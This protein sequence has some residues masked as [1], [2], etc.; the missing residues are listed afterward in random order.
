MTN[1]V[2]ERREK[3]ERQ[4]QDATQRI[5]RAANITD[6]ATITRIAGVMN[7]LHADWFN[8]SEKEQADDMTERLAKLGV[9]VSI[10]HY[11]GDSSYPTE[12]TIRHPQA[13]GSGPTF[14]LALFDWIEQLLKQKGQK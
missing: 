14:D 5:A 4:E 10:A 8:A 11:T 12:Y 3:R 9:T 13:T 6:Q 2:T 7:W 1:K